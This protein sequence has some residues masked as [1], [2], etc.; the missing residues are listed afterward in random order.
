MKAV[1]KMGEMEYE[2]ELTVTLFRG[3]CDWLFDMPN[4]YEAPFSRLETDFTFSSKKEAISD[5]ERHGITIE[6]KSDGA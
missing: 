4:T 1:I 6:D 3:E 5:A 2:G